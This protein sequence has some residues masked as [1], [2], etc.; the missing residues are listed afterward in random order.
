MYPGPIVEP[1]PFKPLPEH[2]KSPSC[3]PGYYLAASPE[4]PVT[5]RIVERRRKTLK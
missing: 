1:I 5:K 3:P 2:L 4:T